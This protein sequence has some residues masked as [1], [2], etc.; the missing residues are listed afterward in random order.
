MSNETSTIRWEQDDDG[1]VVLHGMQVEAH[2]ARSFVGLDVP[3][4]QRRR[5]RAGVD[6]RLD[7]IDTESG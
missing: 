4:V 2:D 5:L 1:I 7:R 3:G 6:L